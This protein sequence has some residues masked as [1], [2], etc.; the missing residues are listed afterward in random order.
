[1]VFCYSSLKGLRQNPDVINSEVVKSKIENKEINVDWA[2]SEMKLACAS[3]AGI[4]P[5]LNIHK[6]I[7]DLPKDCYQ[8]VPGNIV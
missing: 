5:H 6:V 7:T 8:N 3:T 1:M 4:R 2:G